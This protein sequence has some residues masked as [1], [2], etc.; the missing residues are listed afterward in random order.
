M[1]VDANAPATMTVEDCARHLG[2]SR[3]LAYEAVQRGELP[4]IRIGRRVL[5]PRDGIERM[6]SAAP[7]PDAP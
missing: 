6:L 1:D 3:S 5:V 7:A 2:I 4:A